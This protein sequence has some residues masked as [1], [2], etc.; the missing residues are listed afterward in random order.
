MN[1]KSFCIAPWVHT[2]VRSDG[3]L[4][5]CCVWRGP[6]EFKYSNFDQWV[7][8]DK[9]KNVRQSLHSGEK[10]SECSYCW[11]A[12]K[13]GQKSL[14]Q[15]YNSEF[16]KY[17]DFKKINPDWIA[18]DTIVTLDFKLGNVCNLKCVMCDG[19]SSSQL[20]SE[21]KGNK[22]QF[23]LLSFFK[24]PS[25]EI[26]FKW[27]LTESFKT[28]LDQFKN[29]A[30]WVKFTGGEPTLIPYVIDLLDELSNPE[31][32]TVSLTTNA[33]SINTKLLSS[34]SKFNTVWI[35]ASIEGIKEHNDQIRYLSTWS[36]VEQNILLLKNLKNVYFNINYVLQCFSVKTLIPVLRWCEQH[37]LTLENQMLSTPDYLKIDS[38]D[39]DI[40]ED[41]QQELQQLNLQTNQ[42]VVD[43]ILEH[44]KD[45]KFNP[46]LKKQRLQYLSTLDNIRG[47]QLT[48]LI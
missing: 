8:S 35:S 24:K 16:S 22:E 40:V 25:T 46:E 38:V 30:R 48:E 15:I 39:P 21:Y 10:I 20:M 45:Y 42:M 13:I 2:C 37:S 44:L 33:T 31:L 4:T 41:F 17:F 11:G 7:N 27:P 23:N 19:K 14:R 12:E 32:I 5:P 43:Q 47:T 36:E 29:Q 3:Y 28:F 6:G 9:M 1:S 34:L 18:D 26:D